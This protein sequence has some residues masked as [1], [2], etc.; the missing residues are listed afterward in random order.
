MPAKDYR[1]RNLS[2]GAYLSIVLSIPDIEKDAENIFWFVFPPEAEEKSKEYWSG[3]AIVNAK[4]F[5]DAIRNLKER[6]Y[7]K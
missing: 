2:E 5:A 7:S 1:T 4:E 3:K 6:M